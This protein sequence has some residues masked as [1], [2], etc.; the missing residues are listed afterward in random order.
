VA[1]FQSAKGRDY[2]GL[3]WG[4]SVDGNRNVTSL[5]PTALD[6]PSD[7]FKGAVDKW[8]AQAGGP[9]NERN[10]PNQQTLGPFK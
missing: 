6:G 8:N 7:N 4:F 3:S 1:W 2:G 10:G 5:P 9:V